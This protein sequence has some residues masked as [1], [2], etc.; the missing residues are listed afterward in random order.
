[1]NQMEPLSVNDQR[2]GKHQRQ[3]NASDYDGPDRRSGWDER[4]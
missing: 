3:N 2:T 4:S 1:M